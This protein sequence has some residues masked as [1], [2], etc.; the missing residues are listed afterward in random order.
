[1]RHGASDRKSRTF[2]VFNFAARASSINARH[3]NMM[4]RLLPS[5]RRFFCVSF[6]THVE[7]ILDVIDRSGVPYQLTPMRTILERECKDVMGLACFKALQTDCTRVGIN[8]MVDYRAG[9]E[10][11]M[12]QDRQGRS[13][14][15]PADTNVRLESGLVGVT[16]VR[17]QRCPVEAIP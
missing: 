1:V 5:Q 11:R 13:A 17:A 6:S 16:G 7:R 9:T 2:P 15:R 10:S 12:Q 3:A 8:L 4:L 14:T